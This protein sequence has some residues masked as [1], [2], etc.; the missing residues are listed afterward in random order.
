MVSHLDPSKYSQFNQD[1]EFFCY[2][3]NEMG[4]ASFN[5]FFVLV[6]FNTLSLLA[7]NQE[8]KYLSTP[9]YVKETKEAF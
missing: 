4:P 2:F 3:G 6:V 8:N 5:V 1:Y 9:D 7:S